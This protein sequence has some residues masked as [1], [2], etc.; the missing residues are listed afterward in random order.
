[1][2][3]KTS[4]PRRIGAKGAETRRRL[5][6]AAARL[7][8]ANGIAATSLDQIASAAG[9]TKGAIYDHFSAKNDLVFELLASRGSPLLGA[10]D[11][12][13]PAPDQLQAIKD[14]LIASMPSAIGY[15]ARSFEFYHHIGSDPELG[16]RVSAVAQDGLRQIAERIERTPDADRTG[17]NPLELTLALSAL[18]TGLLFH[19]LIAPDMI[20]D[21]VASRIYDR[22]LD[23]EGN[24]PRP[25]SQA[26]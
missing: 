19:R 3:S 7:F 20:T 11:A 4:K 15:L 8:Y 21:A 24:Q 17:L 18:H 13:G 23:G 6:E 1:M 14:F 9:V 16:K 10:L 12:A 25:A 22:L 5:L 26:E 2:V